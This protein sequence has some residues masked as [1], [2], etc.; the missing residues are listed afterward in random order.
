MNAVKYVRDVDLAERYSVHRVTIWRWL[1]QG[2][3]PEPI[4]I[5]GVTRWNLEKIEEF[6]AQRDRLVV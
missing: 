5:G 6:D 2:Y 1:Q 4:K 3:L